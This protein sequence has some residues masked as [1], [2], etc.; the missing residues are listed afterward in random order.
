MLVYFLLTGLACAVAL[1]L[2]TGLLCLVVTLARTVWMVVAAAREAGR[3]KRN[4]VT[5]VAR[6]RWQSSLRVHW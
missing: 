5:A 4:Q 1:V 2:F 3:D 6:D